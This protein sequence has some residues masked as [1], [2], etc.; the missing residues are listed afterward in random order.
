GAQ[1]G[2]RPRGAVPRI[3]GPVPRQACG[4]ARRAAGGGGAL[5]ARARRQLQAEGAAVACPYRAR[6]R[7]GARGRSAGAGDDRRV[8]TTRGSAR[9]DGALAP[10]GARAGP[11]KTRFAGALDRSATLRPLMSKTLIIAEKP[12]V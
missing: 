5:R 4:H 7:P 8:G 3:R 2:D 12:S 11:L 9:P 10:G 1:R 6:L